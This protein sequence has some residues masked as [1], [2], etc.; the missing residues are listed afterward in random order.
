MMVDD[1]NLVRQVEHQVALAFGALQRII[2]RVEL[3]RQIVAERAI[4]AE[5]GVLVGPKQCRDGAQNG[6]DRRYL[7]AFLFGENPSR[8]C[9]GE[10]DQVAGGFLDGDVRERLQR[11]EHDRQQHR[12][13]LVQGLDPHGAAVPDDRQRRID[14]CGVP[15]RVAARIFVVR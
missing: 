7:A 10:P 12:A 1:Q 13:T 9:D 5:I 15:T 11:L 6:E 3:E 2:D 14:D 4:E 8:R